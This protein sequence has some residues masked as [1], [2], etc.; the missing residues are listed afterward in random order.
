[1]RRVGYICAG[2]LFVLFLALSVNFIKIGAR[3]TSDTK[4]KNEIKQL[5]Q[6]ND[7]PNKERIEYRV[8]LEIPGLERL[9]TTKPAKKQIQRMPI[10]DPGNN[11]L[12][13]TP[14]K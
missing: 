5:N 7:N 9:P 10:M 1:M 8:N 12:R 2:A 6:D 14:Y 4:I 13:V 3:E 11:Q